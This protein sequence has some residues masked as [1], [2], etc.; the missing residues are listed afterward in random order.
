LSKRLLMI[1]NITYRK[2]LRSTHRV[3]IH[4]L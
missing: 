2:T 3:C 1:I 4:S